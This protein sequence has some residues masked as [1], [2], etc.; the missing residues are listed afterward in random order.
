MGAVIATI[1]LVAMGGLVHVHAASQFIGRAW[2]IRVQYLNFIRTPERKVKSR[3][4]LR[5]KYHF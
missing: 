1:M 3:D 4:A 2:Q 5:V